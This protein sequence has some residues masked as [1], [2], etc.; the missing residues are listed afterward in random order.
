[1]RKL[2]FAPALVAAALLAAV[3]MGGC[4]DNS[5][6]PVGFGPAGRPSDAVIL[7]SPVADTL[8]N[9]TGLQAT[10]FSPPPANGFRVYINPGNEGYR[11]ATDAPVPPGVSLGSGWSI[12]TA[13]VDGYDPAV[14]TEFIARGARDGVESDISPVTNLGFIAATTGDFLLQLQLVNVTQPGDS[15]G[16]APT[17]AWNA[18]PGATSYLVQIFDTNFLATYMALSTSNVHQFGV[19]PGT[20][21]EQQPMRS[22]PHFMIVQAVDVGGRIFAINFFPHTFNVTVPPTP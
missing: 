20:I 8:G 12:Y 17:L 7:L 19:G 2:H 21:F 9:Y 18:I 15:T 3:G 4:G 5:G 14:A 1:M 16:I 6:N 10:I 11:P 22:G 13:R